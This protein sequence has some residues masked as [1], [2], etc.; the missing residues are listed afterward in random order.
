MSDIPDT[1]GKDLS[2]LIILV[3]GILATIIP[4]IYVLLKG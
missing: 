3:L 2:I 1:S 4:I